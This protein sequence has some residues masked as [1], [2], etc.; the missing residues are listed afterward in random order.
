MLLEVPPSLDV[1]TLTDWAETSL[2]FGNESTL[3]KSTILEALDAAMG[4]GDSLSANIWLEITSRCDISPRGYPFRIFPTRIERANDWQQA[5]CYSFLLLLSSQSFIPSVAAEIAKGSKPAKLFEAVTYYALRNYV[6]NAVMIGFPR[7]GLSPTSFNKC[8]DYICSCIKEK[9][10]ERSPSSNVK[11][12]NVDI[13]AWKDL[14]DRSGKTV[15]FAQCASGKNWREKTREICFSVWRD[16]VEFPFEPAKAF[17][18]PY[19]DNSNWR[20]TLQ[21]S[22][23]F[24]LDRLRLSELILDS[25]ISGLRTEISKWIEDK[26]KLL[27]PSEPSDLPSNEPENT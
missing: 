3:S 15:V 20:R 10:T 7:T 23:G 27:F 11:D 16:Y 24:V 1:L 17:A 2:L 25:D 6:G 8:L 19:I 13:I 21:E 22:E 9:R 14:D 12:E 18:F 4:D 26:V 5:L